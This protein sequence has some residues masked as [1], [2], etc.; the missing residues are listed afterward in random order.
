MTAADIAS[1]EPVN[2]RPDDFSRM[3]GG[4]ALGARLRRL[5]ER[6]DR[7]ATQVYA[8]LGIAFEQRWYGPLLHISRSGPLSVSDIASW[9]RITHVSVSQAV[10]ALDRHGLITSTANPADGRSRLLTLTPAGRD[11][12]DRLTPLWRAFDAAATELDTEA[13]GAAAILSRLDDALDSR[14]LFD[15]IMARYE[16]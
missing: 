6:I 14:S 13:G 5:S 9:L 1:S 15:R 7:D 10:A 3:A 8:A 11:L 12:V 4:A 16:P 2:A